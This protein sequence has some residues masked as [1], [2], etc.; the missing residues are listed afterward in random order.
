MAM[1]DFEDDVWSVK[2][3][4]ELYLYSDGGESTNG[5]IWGIAV[6]RSS[7]P[8]NT[9][10]AVGIFDSVSETSQVQ[11]CSVGLWTGK[12]LDKV[13]QGLCPRGAEQHAMHIQSSA[14]SNTGKLF[15]GGN[16]L[17]RVWNGHEFVNAI[18]VAVYEDATQQWLP[19]KG[20][21]LEMNKSSGIETKVDSLAWDEKNG[22]L[23]IG[24][25]FN[26]LNDKPISPGLALWSEKLGL[27]SFPTKGLYQIGGDGEAMRIAF[28]PITRSLF[29]AGLFDEIGGV[30]CQSIAMWNEIETHLSPWRCLLSEQYSILTVTTMSLQNELLYL[31]GWASPSSTWTG[32]TENNAPYA[33]ATLDISGYIDS[34]QANESRRHHHHA[35]SRI[36]EA[37]G[38]GTEQ[39]NSDLYKPLRSLRNSAEI[40][41]KLKNGEEYLF[42]DDVEKVFPSLTKTKTTQRPT[43]APTEFWEPEWNWLPGYPGGNGPIL[44]ITSG[45][46]RSTSTLYIGGAFDNYG[47]SVIKWS[48]ETIN[49]T[50]I[51]KVDRLGTVQGL[52][53][54]MVVASMPFTDV[55]YPI[56]TARP[57]RASPLPM[58]NGDSW[59]IIISCVLSG[60]ILGVG[61][62]IGCNRKGQEYS[63]IKDFDSSPSR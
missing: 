20:G 46:G 16:F 5:A 62:A 40:E 51:V 24:G 26:T 2:N 10:Y 41:G 43:S 6:N 25:L 30:S 32:M 36:G 42:F 12:H 4:P 52:V 7:K 57:T 49:N 53:T 29:V 48:I 28:E 14:V 22:L 23:Y 58:Q 56:P 61:F 55:K 37:V 11:Y 27:R 21:V 13:G 33:I 8:L 15:V 3:D 31:A 34:F 39:A 45:R 60:I 63:R 50:D 47:S 19:L 44:S 1:Y 38:V 18:N 54:S 9:I 17:S 59:L 35:Y